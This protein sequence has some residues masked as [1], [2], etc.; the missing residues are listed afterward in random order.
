M[1]CR[2]AATYEYT[3]IVKGEPARARTLRG[4]R[5]ANRRRLEAGSQS[6]RG[7]GGFER[8]GRFGRKAFSRSEGGA[9]IRSLRPMSQSL[10]E[11]TRC[12]VP[13][14]PAR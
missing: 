6:H 5:H 7:H 2:F 11:N 1:P 14:A 8:R 12:Q 13:L 4:S 9:R 3:E 10:K